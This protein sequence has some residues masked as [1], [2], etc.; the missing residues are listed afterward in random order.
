LSDD[1]SLSD[2]VGRDLADLLEYAEKAGELNID[3]KE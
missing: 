1:D 2:D 3:D